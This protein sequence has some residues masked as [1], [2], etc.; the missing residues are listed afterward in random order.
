MHLH[1]PSLVLVPDTFLSGSEGAATATGKKPI[2]SSMLVDIIQE[3]FPG[4]PVEP[5]GRKYW[6]DTGGMLHWLH[7][8]IY[9]NFFTPRPRVPS[10]TLR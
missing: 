5:I 8:F 7:T 10:P 4:V 1:S 6:N 3:E 9:F 2:S